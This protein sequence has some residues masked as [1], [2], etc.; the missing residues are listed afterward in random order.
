MVI[1]LFLWDVHS[2][3]SIIHFHGPG[4][5]LPSF[6]FRFWFKSITLTRGNYVSMYFICVSVKVSIKNI[7][8]TLCPIKKKNHFYIFTV[9]LN[10][11]LCRHISASKRNCWWGCG[12]LFV[13]RSHFLFVSCNSNT[14]GSWAGLPCPHPAPPP[15]CGSSG[16]SEGSK[17]TLCYAELFQPRSLPRLLETFFPSVWRSLSA[18]K[19]TWAFSSCLELCVLT[20]SVFVSL[21]QIFLGEFFAFF[22]PCFSFILFCINNTGRGRG[23]RGRKLQFCWSFSKS[24]HY[25]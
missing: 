22:C 11:K 21:F 9:N 20:S 7:Q 19:S 14:P 12:F 8:V 10:W 16:S 4:S 1:F 13:L 23:E 3:M 6:L 5:V 18:L 25:H 15:S 2:D 24:V 17:G